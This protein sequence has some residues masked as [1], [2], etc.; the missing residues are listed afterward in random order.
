MEVGPGSYD[1]N[2]YTLE[3]SILRNNNKIAI[4]TSPRIT[5]LNKWTV[6]QNTIYHI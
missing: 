1:N 2:S 4:Q 6:P 5:D 3:K